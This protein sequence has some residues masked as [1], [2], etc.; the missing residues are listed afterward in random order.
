MYNLEENIKQVRKNILGWIYEY[1]MGNEDHKL[2]R[3]LL[4]ITEEVVAEKL[5]YDNVN[6]IQWDK[7][8]ILF[9]KYEPEEE[10]KNKVIIENGVINI[11]LDDTLIVPNTEYTFK[12][13]DQNKIELLNYTDIY[14]INNNG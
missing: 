5:N 7:L 6:D 13:I 9:G 10:I 1:G 3:M 12:Y 4:N 8:A 14:S 2:R 11:E